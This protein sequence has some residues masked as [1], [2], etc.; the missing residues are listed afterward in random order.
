MEWD[1][2]SINKLSGQLTMYLILA[3]YI[4]HQFPQS[5]RNDADKKAC[6]YHD[7]K[8]QYQNDALNYYNWRKMTK[9][10]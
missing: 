6:K 5:V 9:F 8:T 2:L 7:I 3:L 1:Q 10:N 4:K